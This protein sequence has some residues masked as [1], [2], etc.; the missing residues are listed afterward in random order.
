MKI[1][2]TEEDSKIYSADEIRLSLANPSSPSYLF[3]STRALQNHTKGYVAVFSLNPEGTLKDLNPLHIWQAPTSG[4]GANAIQP[5]SF[6][7][8]K[9]YIALTD[10]QD[11]IVIIISWDGNQLEE[12]A[13]VILDDGAKPATALCFHLQPQ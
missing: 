8:G 6:V 9:E 3:A 7:N 12:I 4:G 5:A 1:I 10:A 11:G 2:P 13:T